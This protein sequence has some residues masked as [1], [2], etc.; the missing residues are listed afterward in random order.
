MELIK[1]LKYASNEV[2]ANKENV[3][4][5]VKECGRAL[6][7]ASVEL[8]ADKE[9][10]LTAVAGDGKSLEY[11]SVELRADKEV[12]LTAVANDGKSLEYASKE[13]RGDK[14]V[15]VEAM[16][17]GLRC[18]GFFY[19]DFRIGN[20]GMDDYLKYLFDKF[21]V[22]VDLFVG[23]ILFGSWMKHIDGANVAKIPKKYFV[24]GKEDSILQKLN[25]LG[26]EG[27]TTF[28]KEIAAFDGV[29]CRD[30]CPVPYHLILTYFFVRSLRCCE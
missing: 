1:H 20:S 18:G 13:L 5:A 15:I 16:N 4:A 12:V 2:R 8:R 22:P 6:K 10:V 7:Y 29:P 24:E 14:E 27:A 3:L 28:K 23:T 26:H 9:V 19:I 21:D 17:N 30:I 11:A 25:G